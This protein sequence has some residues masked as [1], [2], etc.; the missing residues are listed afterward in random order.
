MTKLRRF[1]GVLGCKSIN[2][3]QNINAVKKGQNID[4]NIQ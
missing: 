4:K 3:V 2:C 1:N